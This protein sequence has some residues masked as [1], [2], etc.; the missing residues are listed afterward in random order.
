MEVFFRKHFRI[1]INGVVSVAESASFEFSNNVNYCELF[2]SRIL[3]TLKIVYCIGI[4]SDVV[5]DSSSGSTREKK[6]DDDDV[7]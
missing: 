4:C 5:G 6:E 7:T 1:T 3:K 2:Q